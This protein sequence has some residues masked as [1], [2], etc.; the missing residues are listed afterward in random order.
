MASVGYNVKSE[1]GGHTLCV[2]KNNFS[3]HFV[4]DFY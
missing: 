2:A 3:E 1:E 4:S